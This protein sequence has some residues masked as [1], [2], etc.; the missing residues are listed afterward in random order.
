MEF[1]LWLTFVDR[2]LALLLG[3]YRLDIA[4]CKSVYIEIAN[5]IEPK[6]SFDRTTTKLQS[7]THLDKKKLMAKIDQILERYERDP[8]LVGKD[9]TVHDEGSKIRCKYA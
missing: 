1:E 2:W 4:Q 8:Y 6:T 7:H 9:S 3:R 5:A